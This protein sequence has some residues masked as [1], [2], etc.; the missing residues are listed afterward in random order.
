MLGVMQ[1]VAL[2]LVGVAL[3]PALAHALELPGKKRLTQDAYLAVQTIYYPGFTI[4]GVAEPLGVIST[5]ILLCLTPPGG[6]EF[7]LTLVALL[8]LL[9][10]Q[11]VYWLITHPVNRYWLQGQNLSSLGSGFFSVASAKRPG[12]QVETHSVN[13]TVLRDRW[14]YSHLVRAILVLV[15][16][17]ALVLA[18]VLGL[19]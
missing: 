1:V 9:E 7:W 13:W 10:M 12:G 2:I 5:I 3:V 8:G 16:L 6:V 18:L 14:E 4:A 17:V 15:S 19:G 11:L